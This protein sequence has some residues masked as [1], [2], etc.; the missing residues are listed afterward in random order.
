MTGSKLGGKVVDLIR[1]GQPMQTFQGT[2]VPSR[3]ASIA[4]TQ[5]MHQTLEPNQGRHCKRTV[6]IL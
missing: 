1:D 3:E 4:S 2:L 6:A 5:W